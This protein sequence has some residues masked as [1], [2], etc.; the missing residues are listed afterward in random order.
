MEL[1]LPLAALFRGYGVPR[2]QKRGAETVTRAPEEIHESCRWWQMTLAEL[3]RVVS[4]AL[5]MGLDL[6][7]VT[8]PLLV[9]LRRAA[10]G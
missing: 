3:E 4:F 2:S 5:L 7:K 10:N 1:R 8:L 6:R 9:R